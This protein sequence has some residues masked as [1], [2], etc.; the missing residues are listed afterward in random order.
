MPMPSEGDDTSFQPP[1]EYVEEI[2][3]DDEDELDDWSRGVGRGTGCGNDV[4]CYTKAYN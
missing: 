4:D 3:E 2:V 1:T